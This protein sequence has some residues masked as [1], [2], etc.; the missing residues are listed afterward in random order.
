M[1]SAEPVNRAHPATLL[2]LLKLLVFTAAVP[3]TVTVWLP[4]FYIFPALR[5]RPVAWNG[6]ALGGLIPI[7]LG[8]A[9]YLWCA[10]DFAFAGKGTPA[11]ID[12]PKVLVARGL[13]KFSRNPM[14]LSVL[15]VLAGES[16][17]FWSARLLGYAAWVAVGFHLFVYFYEEPNLKRRMGAE[18]SQYLADVPRWIFL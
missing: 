13:Y 3:G 18:Y 15:L 17:F 16:L 4:L 1:A 8:T 2:L 14:Y 9:G 10:L 12:P 6:S 11:P 5:H 7:A